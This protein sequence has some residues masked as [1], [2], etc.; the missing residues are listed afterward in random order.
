MRSITRFALLPLLCT[1]A[2]AGA[3]AASPAPLTVTVEGIR[4]GKR[5]PDVNAFC[6]ATTDGKSD[7][8]GK[9][10]RPTIS[11][12]G[13]PAS[14]QSFAIFVHDT[15]VPADFTDAG[16]E[17][18]TLPVAAKRQDFFHY[19]VI[20]IPAGTSSF[21]GGASEV[22]PAVGT[23]LPNDMGINKYV[24]SPEQFG[25]PCPPWNDERLHHYHFNVL[26]FDTA[27]D[28]AKTPD[29]SETAKAAYQRLSASPHL[30][31]KGEIVGTYSLNP[32]MK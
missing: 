20:H 24:A 5:I 31:A 2:G 12:S 28:P 13:A 9:N 23:Q 25:G 8:T 26:A 19:G 6:L 21:P 14:A 7:H 16:K 30:V 29:S 27:V 4:D 15:D 1:I 17:G 32:K 22:K 10:L 18:K 11:W 3:Q